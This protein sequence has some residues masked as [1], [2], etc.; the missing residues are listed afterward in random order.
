MAALGRNPLS[1]FAGLGKAMGISGAAAAGR[2][3]DLVARQVLYPEFVKAQISYSRVGLELVACLLTSSPGK[4]PL[5]ETALD[6]HPYTRY[7]IRCMGSVSGHFVLFAV[8]YG[9]FHLL[10]SFLER[11]TGLWGFAVE[12]EL[13]PVV[14]EPMYGETDF[15]LLG[16]G[17]TWEFDWNRWKEVVSSERKTLVAKRPSLLHLLDQRDMRVLRE[18]SIDYRKERKEV[19]KAAGIP[20]YALSKRVRFYREAGIIVGQRMAFNRSVVGLLANS[21][22]LCKCAVSVTERAAHAISLLPFQSALFPVEGGFLLHLDQ[23]PPE[24]YSHVGGLMEELTGKC[25]SMWC[26]YTS[27]RRYYFDNEPTNFRDK[28]WRSSSEFMVDEVLAAL[29]KKSVS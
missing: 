15:A 12:F 11:L 20:T 7:R 29:E 23:F 18:L 8:P 3:R 26:D 25:F 27:S 5:V 19:A 21:L 22:F 4:W 9:T 6:L 24:N 2:V 28:G 13:F 17:L 1:S 16:K 10:S 14:A